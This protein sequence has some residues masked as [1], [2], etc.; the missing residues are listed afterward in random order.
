VDISFLTYPAKLLSK[1]VERP[2]YANIF[3]FLA[4]SLFPLALAPYDYWVLGILAPMFLLLLTR[5]VTCKESALRHYLF[6]VGMYAW[7]LYWIYVSV[8]VHGHAPPVLAG[9]LVGLLVITLAIPMYIQG[10]VFARYFRF[11][12]VAL[13]LGFA[14]LW[15]FREWLFT[16]V[17]TGFPWLLIG[18]GHLYTPI[19][20]YAPFLG[21]LGVSFFGVLSSSLLYSLLW[22]RRLTSLGLLLS[23]WMAGYGI[24]NIDLVQTEGEL[25]KVSLV[26]GNID[27]ETKWRREMVMPII[28]TYI[29]LSESEWGR[30]IIIWP[31]AALTVY[32][33]DAEKFL[34]GLSE[35]GKSHNTSLVL[36]LPDR[37]DSGDVFNAAI[38]LGNGEGVYHKRLLVPFGEYIPFEAQLR[39]LIKAFD[40]PMSKNLTGPEYQPLLKAGALSLSMS[41]CYEIIYPDL[42][43]QNKEVP[44]LLTTIS[45]DTWFGE[46][47]GPLQHL[48]M[49]QMRALEQKRY[50][51]RGTNNGVTAIVGPDGRI[52]SRL[53]QFKAAVL[54]GEIFAMKG[55]TPYVE[56]GNMPILVLI[57]GL[58][59]TLMMWRFRYTR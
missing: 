32:R 57:F 12:T 55:M 58:L 28:E 7:G 31:E 45:N 33:H 54:R 27:Q 48:Q 10:Y 59:L 53:P 56:F 47:I 36:G 16:W 44:D 35:K 26:Q 37:N 19:G 23:L 25:V 40:L 2:L 4:G 6:A 18:Y 30:D 21:V 3:A 17:L 42:V 1:I 49:A 11:N 5:K 51:L 13:V 24:S 8:H 39:G 43:R 46:S 14:L 15:T 38:V 20:S 29:D 34:Q 9:A 52:V 22:E 41:I 50:L